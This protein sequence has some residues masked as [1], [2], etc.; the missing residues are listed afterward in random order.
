MRS[1]I[2]DYLPM[3]LET[4]ADENNE[5][6]GYSNEIKL[7]YEIAECEEESQLSMPKWMD[8]YWEDR[9]KNKPVKAPKKKGAKAENDDEQD[10]EGADDDVDTRVKPKK[11]KIKKEKVEEG[12][13]STIDSKQ[14]KVKSK[15]TINSGTDNATKQAFTVPN[16]ATPSK[17]R[18]KKE[19][20]GKQ[21]QADPN[22]KRK[23]EA[24][25][26]IDQDESSGLSDAPEN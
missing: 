8:E 13:S 20:A 10:E 25:E 1:P 2:T 14:S 24:L 11:K 18:V 17:P 5:V 4:P 26:R 22:E 23:A 19:K 16:Q 21:K 9:L 6:S 15:T 12:D 3:I 7:L